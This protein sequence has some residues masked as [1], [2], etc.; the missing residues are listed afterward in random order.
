MW[1]CHGISNKTTDKIIAQARVNR[2]IL[3]NEGMNK[4][5]NDNNKLK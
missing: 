2:P 4:V 5:N 3:I 1:T